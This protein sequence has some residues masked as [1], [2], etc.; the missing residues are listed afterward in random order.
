MKNNSLSGNSVDSKSVL[1]IVGLLVFGLGSAVT[2]GGFLSKEISSALTVL[3]GGWIMR[4]KNILRKYGVIYDISSINVILAY[5]TIKSYLSI[6][7][8]SYGLFAG[9]GTGLAYGVAL[10]VPL[11]VKILFY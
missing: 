4:W 10:E 9:I 5:F 8:I 2:A 7:A 6:L 11:K 1:S 3:I